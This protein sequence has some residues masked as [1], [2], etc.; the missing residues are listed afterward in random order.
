[1]RY[2]KIRDRLHKSERVNYI[3]MPY[4][5][6]AMDINRVK[7]FLTQNIIREILN[8]RNSV[9]QVTEKLGLHYTIDESVVRS[10]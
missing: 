3:V 5:S 9:T 4:A 2:I 10:S 8:G 6:D 1:M 7:A